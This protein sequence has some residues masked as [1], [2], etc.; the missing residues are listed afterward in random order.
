MAN[1]M[2]LSAFELCTVRVILQ[3]HQKS[4]RKAGFEKSDAEI[5]KSYKFS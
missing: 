3:T 4:K 5:L 1:R 2:V